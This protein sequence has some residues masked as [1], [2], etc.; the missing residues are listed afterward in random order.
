MSKIFFILV[1]CS[2]F[3]AGACKHHKRAS[4]PA[5][6]DQE[7]SASDRE[8][9]MTAGKATE[10]ETFVQ[11]CIEKTLGNDR[12]AL[13][14][15]QECLHMN[16]GNAAANYEVAGLYAKSGQKDRAVGYAK[17]AS[18]LNP[19]NPWYRIRYAELLLETG[20]HE[21]AAKIYKA[22]SDSQP[23]NVDY[24]FYYAS[25]LVKTGKFDD[26]LSVYARIESI[27]G[28]SDTLAF[29]RILVYRAKNDP[30]GE[31]K[32]IRD[33]LMAFPEN[34]KHYYLLAD[35]Y[36]SRNQQ[37]KAAEVCRKMISKFPTLVMPRLL[38]AEIYAAQNQ[39]RPAFSEAA[40]AFALPDGMQEK[41]ALVKNW[42]PV[43][44]TSAA[45]SPAQ[46]KEADS[47]CSILRRV[48]PDDAGTFFLSGDYLYKEEKWK[49]AREL[50]RKGILLSDASYE[51][52]LRIL[53]IND[54]LK[55]HA[56]QLKDCALVIE[57]YPTQPEPYYY[58]GMVHYINKDYQKAIA[59]LE[60]AKDLNFQN[61]PQELKIM[62]GLIEA[63]R[64]TGDHLKADDL[65]EKI[66][67][68]PETE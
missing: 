48:H 21:A 25:A 8:N 20:Q 34:T 29:S 41:I 57:S 10:E 58:R 68:M 5:P 56:A 39:S 42:Y 63:Y 23:D 46:Q 32:T 17:T 28:I 22:L 59:D 9:G 16:P 52:F 35:F 12:L 14:F 47:L 19:A 18:T 30:A 13:G 2:V 53:L 55:D 38:L 64:A 31:E 24:L 7:T 45:L 15:F 40:K 44:D 61:R 43:S 54:R 60:T 66:K 33:L 6:S 27:E 37:E 65:A 26:A 51:L 62:L 3:L 11:G 67:N 49:E 1:I 4:G 50:Y 36:A